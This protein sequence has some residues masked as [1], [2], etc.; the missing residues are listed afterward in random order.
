MNVRDTKK[1]RM[2]AFS[3]WRPTS[4]PFAR[5]ALSPSARNDTT[6]VR[7]DPKLESPAG[8]GTC[9]GSETLL[10]RVSLRTRD[11]GSVWRRAIDPEH[12]RRRTHCV[13]NNGIKPN[14]IWPWPPPHL[15]PCR[16][17]PSFKT[18][19]GDRH[20]VAKGITCRR[21]GGRMI[22]KHGRNSWGRSP[23]CIKTTQAVLGK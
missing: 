4:G 3:K 18:S 11:R 12:Y 1:S 10:D 21:T 19:F 20:D 13:G 2:V 15:S 14:P 17:P 23:N 7:E 22:K 16:V 6:G 5:T 8:T 9:Q